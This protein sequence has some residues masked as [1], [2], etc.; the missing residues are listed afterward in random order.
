MKA[1]LQG[2][3]LAGC[4]LFVCAPAAAMKPG[5]LEGGVVVARDGDGP[6][7]KYWLNSR[8]AMAFSLHWDLGEDKNVLRARW[9]YLVHSF[10]RL[11]VEGGKM[12]LYAGLGVM[13][14]FGDGK[15]LG[16]RFPLGASYIYNENVLDVFFEVAPYF[17]LTPS[18]QTSL[19][20]SMGIRF[21][22]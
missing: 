1:F 16:V 17:F 20:G 13:A 19:S 21:F 14:W 18:V 5:D 10:D 4:L 22:L 12:P 15:A 3:G 2:L 9:D 11:E 8:D 7:L 6:S